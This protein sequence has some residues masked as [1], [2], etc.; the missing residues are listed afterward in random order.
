MFDK[1]LTEDTFTA[2]YSQLCKDLS[3]ELPDFED[4][5]HAVDAHGKAQR[6][7]FRRILLN[8]CQSEFEQ[9]AAAAAAVE[10]RERAAQDAGVRPLLCAILSALW[11]G[12]GLHELAVD[13]GS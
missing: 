11:L 8:K 13:A 1:A 9:G 6:I 5:E 7:T 10:T 12:S 2:L 3:A 4:P